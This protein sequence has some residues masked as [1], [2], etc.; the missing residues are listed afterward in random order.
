MIRYTLGNTLS[1]DS[2]EALDLSLGEYAPGIVNIAEVSAL[3]D[4]SGQP[5]TFG[6][7]QL[8]FIALESGPAML[9]WA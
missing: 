8:L 1:G 2:G 9:G 4:L 3:A 7:V 6:L 5:R